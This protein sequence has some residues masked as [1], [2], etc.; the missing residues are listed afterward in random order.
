MSTKTGIQWTDHTFNPW[1]GCQKVSPGCTNCYAETLSVRF[2]KDIWGPPAHSTRRT[3]GD[4][5]WSDPVK[6]NVAAERE[7]RRHRVFCASMADVFE[8]HPDVK[9]E[10]ERLWEL[11][12]STPWLHWQILTKR[13]ENVAGMV[14]QRWR[15]GLPFW[16][17]A[18]VEDQQR[19]DE[20]IPRLLSLPARIHFL[21]AEPLI[22]PVDLAAWW[23]APTFPGPRVDWVIVGGESG[24][25]ARPMHLGWARSLVRQCGDAGTAAFVK[26]LGS[27]PVYGVPARAEHRYQVTGKGGDPAEW[28]LDLRVREFP[29]A[30]RP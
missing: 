15:G 13:P 16:L 28:P 2:G 5:H 17:G 18:S 26:Q 30:V 8:D 1:W 4:K 23:L 20:R 10:R 21:S 11:I 29:E 12:E 7:G 14:P 24:P 19:A 9:G 22:G 25:G 3:F 6:W 27:L